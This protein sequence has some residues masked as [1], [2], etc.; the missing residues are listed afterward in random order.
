[1]PLRDSAPSIRILPHRI[2]LSHSLEPI[3]DQRNGAP[4]HILVTIHFENSFNDLD[5]RLTPDPHLNRGPDT[6]QL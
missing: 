1:M 6:N 3:I 2:Q 4:V 5:S